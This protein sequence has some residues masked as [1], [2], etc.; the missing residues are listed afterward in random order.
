M[1]QFELNCTQQNKGEVM[2]GMSREKRCGT[3]LGFLDS[4]SQQR[5]RKEQK[6]RKKEKYTKEKKERVRIKFAEHNQ[7]SR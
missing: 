6:E 1:N 5:R 3:D 7:F 2:D 4:T